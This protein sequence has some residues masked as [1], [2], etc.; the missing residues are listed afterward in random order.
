MSLKII[1]VRH[2]ETEWNKILRIQGAKSDSPL[3]QKGM[4]QAQDLASRLEN[5][6]IKAVYSSPLKRAMNTAAA[7]AANQ[8]LKVITEGA[9]REIEAGE[10]EGVTTAELGMRFS[11]YLTRNGAEKRIPGGESL[12]DLQERCR[13]FIKQAKKN[14]S[15]GSIVMVSHYFTILSAVCAVLE[16]PLENIIRMRMKNASISVILFENDTPR[17]ETF[18]DTACITR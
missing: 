5:E 13:G 1:L 10:L 6:D 2:G 7:I 17:L 4:R 3:N 9:L 18:N 16:L 11:D 15:G 8:C 12:A 14:H